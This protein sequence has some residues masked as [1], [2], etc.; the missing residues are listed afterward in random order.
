[1]NRTRLALLCLAHLLVDTIATFLTPLMPL[2]EMRLQ[3][4][5]WAIGI[6][7]T[8]SLLT[9]SFSQPV[10]GYLS[11]RTRAGGWMVE[12]GPIV[13]LVAIGCIGLTSHYGMLLL[14]VMVSG[15]G[16]AA[17]HPE[18][19]ALASR[20]SRGK[21]ALGIS[22][23][24]ISGHVG[25]GAGPML[26]GW[27][28]ESQGIEASWWIIPP[29]LLVLALLAL[30]LRGTREVEIRP[31]A[32]SLRQLWRRHQRVLGLLL[33]LSIIR[34]FVG[35][36]LSFCLPFWWKGI[37]FSEQQIGLLS[38]CF[39][40][41]GG[42]AGFL[43]GWLIQP[44]QERRWIIATFVLAVPAFY[45]LLARQDLVGMLVGVVLAGALLNATIPTVVVVAQRLM[46]G[47]ESVAAALMLGVAWGLGGAAAPPVIRWLQE[48]Y[49]D[50]LVLQGVGLALVPLIAV[51]WW[52]PRHQAMQDNVTSAK[53]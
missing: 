15:F 41:A 8:C 46:A 52:L 21:Q 10:W 18:A 14:L 25:L 47:G 24:V 26:S 28:V 4:A 2:L 11:D 36:S 33:T 17:F 1:M 40:F 20:A 19:A 5:G 53:N 44:G 45:F 39:L 16:V 51:A 29:G 22:L 9:T 48:Q 38:G 31:T 42:A 32:A 50:V 37:G 35:I 3:L 12:V 23:F 13:A 49:G 6:V 7:G 27:L 34:S 30:A 43:C